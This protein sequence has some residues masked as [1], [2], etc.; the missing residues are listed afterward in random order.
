MSV[1]VSTDERLAE[2]NFGEDHPFGPRRF[3][4]FYDSLVRSGG[5]VEVGE[6]RLGAS[7]QLARTHP[8]VAERLCRYADSHCEGKLLAMGGG[9][10]NLE[11]IAQG[12]NAAVAAMAETV[13]QGDSSR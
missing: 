9:G 2:Y 8:Y 6:S 4:A 11:N 10:Y 12:W 1:L 5:I 3:H 7:N 13:M